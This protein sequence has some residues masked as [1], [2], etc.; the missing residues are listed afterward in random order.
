MA[1]KSFLLLFILF[2]GFLISMES[3]QEE[4]IATDSEIPLR[5]SLDTL[6]FDTVFTQA[7]SATRSFKIYNDLE[8]TVILNSVGLENSNNSF[9]RINVDGINLNTVENIRIEPTD[10]IYVFAE[11]TI[12]PDN[13]LSISPF[14][15][16]ENVNITVNNSSYQVLLEAWGQNANYIPNRESSGRVSLLSCDFNTVTWDDPKPY[17]LFVMVFLYLLKMVH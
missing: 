14:F 12:D 4:I 3:C 6:R 7:G 5:F 9:F 10:S 17:V 15:I 8:E 2:L 13:P 11:V 1:N 16:E